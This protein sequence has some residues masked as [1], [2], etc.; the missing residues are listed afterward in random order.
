MNVKNVSKI[1]K[2]RNV[3]YSTI[4]PSDSKNDLQHNQ[5]PVT[6]HMQ[7]QQQKQQQQHQKTYQKIKYAFIK[8]RLDDF[9]EE[10]HDTDLSLA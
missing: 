10:P 3:S 2:E 1:I 4:S 7:Q 9:V 5:Y 6:Q 8:R